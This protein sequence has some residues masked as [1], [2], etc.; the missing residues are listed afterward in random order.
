MPDNN[1]SS[2]Y[3][4]LEKLEFR[5]ELRKSFLNFFVTN[6][7]VVLLLIMLLAGA[8]IYSYIALPVESDPEVKIPIAIVTTVFPGA[9]PANVEDLVTEKLETEIAGLK[10]I[11]KITSSSSNSVSSI[12]VEFSA[13]ADLEGSIRK[14]RDA[15]DDARE[16][17]PEDAEDPVVAEISVDDTPIFSVSIAGPYDGF[18][19]RDFAEDVQAELE[20]ISGVREVMVSGGDEREFEIAYDPEKLAFYGLSPLE[21]NRIV[22]E[23][24]SQVPGGN[25]QGNDYNYAVRTDARFFDAEALGNIPVFHTAGGAIIY[26]KDMAEVR[27]R[28]IKKTVLSHFSR[29]GEKPADSVNIDII[30]KTGGSIIKTADASKEKLDEM[31]KDAPAGI[32]YDITIDTAKEIRKNFDQL[33]HDFILTIILVF[34][35]LFLVIGLKEALVA[36]L[37]I[38]L[39]FFATFGVM[40]QVGISLNF[41]SMISLILALGLLVDDA[42][43]VVS[44]TKQYL[45]TGK[46]TPEEAV[47]L[48]LNDFK[49]VLFTTTLTTVWAFLPL[50]FASGIIGEYIRSIPITVSVTLLASL[51]IALVINHP[52]AAVLERVRLTRKMFFIW[53]ALAASV[54]I[55]G[56]YAAD[57][58][59]RTVLMS[60]GAIAAYWMLDWYFRKGKA[61]LLANAGLMER[62]WRD[63]GLIKEKLRTQGDHKDGAFLSRLIHG[64]IRFDRLI[65]VYEK[66]LRKILVTKKRRVATVIFVTVLLLTAVAL[67]IAG[68]VKS[69]F[70]P[71]TDAE[72]MFINIEAP[73][74]LRLEETGKIVSQV[75]ERLAGYPEIISLSTVVGS[76]GFSGNFV[77]SSANPSHRAQITIKLQEEE[78]RTLKSYEFAEVVR[79]DIADI[80]GAAITVQTLSGG[81]PAGA[82]FEAQILGEDLDVLDGIAQDLKPILSSVPGVVDAEISL[83][84]SPADYVFLLDHGRMELLGID[85]LRIGSTIRM[86]ISGTEVTEIIKGGDEIKVVARF[87][88]GKIPDLE[89]LQNLQIKNNAGESIF[90]RDVARIRL[91]PSV[92]KI[93]RINQRRAVLLS[94]GVSGETSSTDAVAEFQNKIKDYKLP[95]GYEI[96]YGGENEQNAE[97]VQSIIRAMVIALILIIATLVIQFNSFKKTF[98]VLVT[99]PLALI[100]VFFG[101]ALFGVSLSFPALIGVVALFG[102]VVKNAIILVD[103]INLN[104]RTGIAFFEA[105]VD[106]GKSRLEA[107]SIT[108]ICTIAGITPVTLSNETWLAMGSTIIFGLFL[109]SFLTLFVIPTLY[110]MMIDKDSDQ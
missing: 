94:A 1:K 11:D 5:P 80:Q 110:V 16:N 54:G 38:P 93:T 89:A 21:A 23:A 41:L 8:G 52:L 22:A 48:V 68:V 77:N 76:G 34:A 79:R 99:I 88:E 103:K 101:L 106:A 28:A 62:E 17:L 35:I 65:P 13:K 9:S 58:V 96:A 71:V 90:L 109:S 12:T 105:V 47:L 24:N 107:I 72:L 37:A 29:Q 82:A 53:L 66:Y 6:F 98:I 67:P 102:I 78:D 4:Y 60:A 56:W 42:I 25:F 69:E 46:F 51:A 81:P 31:I 97:S 92:D 44:A 95:P 86:A 64:I 59:V 61:A 50:L 84:S 30:K 26:L 20:K 14:L 63:D 27:D 74:G 75:E 83:K 73:V 104:I 49:V 108:S 10:D 91:E 2:D 87:G 45:R 7:R 33:V 32:T 18:V 40:L 100:G 3:Q 85:A 70:F 15:V 43:V 36:S 39:V 19:L 57:L 55:S